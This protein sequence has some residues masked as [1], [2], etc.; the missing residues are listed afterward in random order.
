M[1]DGISEEVSNLVDE[2]P[3]PLAKLHQYLVVPALQDVQMGLGVASA[4]K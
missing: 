2:I 1:E 3:V 4:S